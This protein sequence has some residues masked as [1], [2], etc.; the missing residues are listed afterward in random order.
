MPVPERSGFDTIEIDNYE[1]GSRLARHILSMRPKATI[2]FLSTPYGTHAGELRRDGIRTAA[3]NL[4]GRETLLNCDFDD[5]AALAALLRKVQPD[6]VICAHDALAARTAP[7]LRAIGRR[8]PEDVLLASFDDTPIAAAMDPPL[9]VIRQSS[10]E[11]ARMAF[12]TLMQ[13]IVKPQTGS[14]SKRP[15]SFAGQRR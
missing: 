9:T 13:R 8:I 2:A 7:A 14:C 4:G 11:L 10:K 12:A 1:A 6:A 3:V 5:P 15:L